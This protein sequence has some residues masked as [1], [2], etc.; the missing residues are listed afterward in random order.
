MKLSL[1]FE[2]ISASYGYEIEDLTYDSG[3]ENV[4]KARLKTKRNQLDA[5]MMMAATDPVM[6]APVFHGAFRFADRKVL[7]R[8]VAAQPDD[9][10]AWSEVHAAL[11]MDHWA[12]ALVERV[13]KADGGEAF[14]LVAAGL[15]YI[16][17]GPGSA[18]AGAG[19]G[20]AR[21]GGGEEAG[22]EDADADQDG[23]DDDGGDYDGEDDDRADLGDAGE[24]WL[25]DQGFDRR[26]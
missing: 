1:F 6:V 15:E 12:E 16:E 24:D 8:L 14:M 21:A 13:L 17:S 10:P 4:L 18:P 7:D 20:G 25:D 22:D 23:A 26:S 3:G 19:K 11:D 5:L 2:E 9:F